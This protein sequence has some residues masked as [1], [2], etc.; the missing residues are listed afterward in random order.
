LTDHYASDVFDYQHKFVTGSA[1][2]NFAVHEEPQTQLTYAFKASY[3]HFSAMFDPNLVLVG[4]NY[5]W[6]KLDFDEYDDRLND[7]TFLEFGFDYGHFSIELGAV[8]TI[9]FGVFV[10]DDFL[11]TNT[12]PISSLG[13]VYQ[14]LGYKVEGI[15]GKGTYDG[16][17]LD[18][19]TEITYKRLNFAMNTIKNWD[20]NYSLILRD[21]ELSGP[22]SYKSSSLT[23]ALLIYHHINYR[24]SWGALLSI[25]KH[26]KEVSGTLLNRKDDNLYPKGGGSISLSF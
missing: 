6:Q 26:S 9:N 24:I 15:F 5:K 4:T 1:P 14:N 25:E 21:L 13:F 2:M 23:N 20:L 3:F 8:H 19:S 11:E 10:A 17:L 18:S 7:T 12:V 22:M 16:G